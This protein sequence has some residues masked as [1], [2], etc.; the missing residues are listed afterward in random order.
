MVPKPFCFMPNHTVCLLSSSGWLES[1]S[2]FP[3]C[4]SAAHSQPDN[5]FFIPLFPAQ[6]C[7]R[8][9]PD[10]CVRWITVVEAYSPHLE[11]VT[12][13]SIP[14]GRMLRYDPIM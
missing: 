8:L 14:I 3:K 2:Q 4:P 7:P 5:A 12:V 11:R 1:A 13:Q 9:F 6:S 10:I